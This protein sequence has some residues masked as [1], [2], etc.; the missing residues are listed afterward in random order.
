VRCD[1]AALNR[2]EP[3]TAS[4]HHGVVVA[5]GAVTRR[6]GLRLRRAKLGSCERC[7]PGALQRAFV[8]GARACSSP[9]LESQNA[10]MAERSYTSGRPSSSAWGGSGAA[11]G[12]DARQDPEKRCHHKRR[13]KGA[14][15][16]ENAAR[17][18]PRRCR[19]RARRKTSARRAP[20]RRAHARPAT[21]QQRLLRR[22]SPAPA[23]C[24]PLPR[25]QPRSEGAARTQA[26]TAARRGARRHAVQARLWPTRAARSC[27]SW[28]RCSQHTLLERGASLP[29]GGAARAREGPARRPGTSCRSGRLPSPALRASLAPL[30][31]SAS[32]ASRS[33]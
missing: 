1:A 19:R 13:R 32:L 16:A 20:G 11:G 28:R 18:A 4:T 2:R 3:A 7:E 33:R 25:A 21:P 30:L 23:G 29:R 14:R 9:G 15:Q 10:W 27:A 31:P 6:R 5:A 12:R 8:P 26:R 22:W 17:V 24:G